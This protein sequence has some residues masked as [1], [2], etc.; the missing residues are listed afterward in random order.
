MSD[1][2]RMYADGECMSVEVAWMAKVKLMNEQQGQYHTFY[3]LQYHDLRFSGRVISNSADTIAQD[4]GP[5]LVHL[6]IERGLRRL[7][8]MP[9]RR[10][11]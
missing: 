3:V 10:T 7:P 9:G 2:E 11:E 4:Y 5:V 8:T 1:G 6:K